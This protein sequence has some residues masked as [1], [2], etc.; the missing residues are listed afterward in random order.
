MPKFSI[1]CCVSK[2]DVF[3][4]C[5]LASINE[6]RKN[7]DVE[8]IP[9]INNDNRYSASNALNVGIDA[10]QSDILIFAHQDVKLLFDW[11]DILSSLIQEI[12]EDWGVLGSAGIALNYGRDDIGRWGGSLNVDTVAVGSVWSDV[13]TLSEPPY[14]DGIKELTP[15]HCADECL[16]VVNKQT[17]LR[18]DSMFGGFHFYGVDMCLQARAAGYKVFCAHLPIIHFGKYSASFTGDK[19]YWTY[20]RFLHHKWRLRFPEMLGTHMHWADNELTSYIPVGLEANDGSEIN[21]KAMGIKKAKL[22][23][24]RRYG[25]L[26]LPGLDDES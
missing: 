24:D 19:K 13:D 6:N 15:A 9:I 26:D 18:F 25:L 21:L 11:F 12:P 17:G 5:L 16:I 3:D 20:L 14:W 10:S 8:I 2:A 22:Q 4:E 1:I 7:H 23:T